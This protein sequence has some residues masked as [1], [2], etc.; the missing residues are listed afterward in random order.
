MRYLFPL[1]PWNQQRQFQ[2]E[3]WVYPVH[4][5]MYATHLRDKGFEVMWNAK[6]RNA[7]DRVILCDED[8]DTPFKQLPFPDRILTDAKNQRYQRYGNYKFH[9]ATHMMVS[10]LCWWGKCVFC[11]DKKKIEGRDGV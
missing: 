10:N 11:E 2:K 3:T 8:I 1:S 7:E 6:W 5:A 4:L 9:P